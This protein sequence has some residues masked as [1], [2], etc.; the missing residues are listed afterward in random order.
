MEAVRFI[1]KPDKVS[2]ILAATRGFLAGLVV[3]IHSQCFFFL[4]SLELEQRFICSGCV[5]EDKFLF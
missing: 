5:R 4:L 3:Q 1:I 2:A